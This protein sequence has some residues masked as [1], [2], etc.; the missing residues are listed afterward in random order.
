MIQSIVFGILLLVFGMASNP[1][2]AIAQDTSSNQKPANRSGNRLVHLDEPWEVFHPDHTF[3]R[4]T[5]PQWIGEEGIEL[6]LALGIDDMRDIPTYEAYLRPIL[7]Q[8]KVWEGRA[9]VSIMANRI[10]PEDPHLQEWLNEGVSIE[11]HTADHPCP[12][13]DKG[14]FSLAKSTYDR[15]VDSLFLIPNHEP[16]AFRTPC[17]DGI[18]SHSPRLVAEILLGTTPE[19]RFLKMSSSVGL[20]FTAADPDASPDLVL[21]PGGA[22]RFLRYRRPGYIGYIENYPFP[23]LV[24]NR[25]WE[26][27]FNMPD[28]YEGSALSGNNSPQTLHDM[29]LAIDWIAKKQ[30]VWMLCFHP[31]QWIDNTNVIEILRHA[32][33]THAGKVRTLNLRD[34][35]ERLEKNLLL[36]QPL[37]RADGSDNGVR[38]VDLSN[39]GTMDV[40]IGNPD[41]QVTR[42]W[43]PDN[44][45]WTDHDFPVALVD[46]QGRPTGARF[47]LIHADGRPSLFHSNEKSRGAWQLTA[48]GWVR[49]DLL[50]QGLELDGQ[51]VLGAVN[52]VDAGLRFR[53]LDGDG[54]TECI[55]ARPGVQAVFQWNP[56]ANEWARLELELPEGLSLV[57]VD[58]QDNGV[59]FVDING[60]GREDLI[61][62]NPQEYGLWFYV[63]KPF[64]GFTR[65]F[66]REIIRQSRGT[67]PEIPM[68]V[69]GGE[70]SNNGAWFKFDH[71]WVQNEETAH[72]ANHVDRLTFAELAN[73]LQPPPSDPEVS[74]VQMRTAGDYVIELVAH[75]LQITDPVYFDWDADGSLWVVEMRDYPLGSKGGGRIR[76]LQDFD[77]DGF[78]ETAVTFIEDLR[79]PSG[80]YPWRDGLLISAAPNLLYA[81]DTTGDGKADSVEVLF[82]GFGEGNQQH[83]F[84]GFELGLDNWIHG[85]NGD[86]GGR[87][88]SVRTGQT[89]DISGRDFKFR[90][91]TG[92]LIPTSGQTQYTRR[93]DDWGNWFGGANNSLG[94]H[95]KFP[96]EAL[97]RNPR[98]AVRSARQ[99]YAQY[100][101]ANAVHPIARPQQ[102]FNDVGTAGHVTSANS[103]SPYRDDLFEDDFATS[104]FISEPTYNLVRREVLR[105][106]G[107]SF[108]SERSSNEG[109]EEFLASQ[110]P[111]FRPTLVRT[112]PDAALYVADMYRWV[113]EH[114]EWI[115]AD[116][117]ARMDVRAGEDRGRLYRIRPKDRALRPVHRLD[118]AQPAGWVDALRHPNGWVR[119]TAHRLFL[120]N[121]PSGMVA[122]LTGLVRNEPSPKTRLQA[123]CILDGLSG[124][125]PELLVDALEDPEPMIR[126]HAV[127]IAEPWLKQASTENPLDPA[128]ARLLL[129]RVTDPN[130]RVRF[131]LALSLGEWND[132]IAGNALAQLLL[133]E[134]T[135][136]DMRIAVLSSAVPHASEMLTAIIHSNSES[137]HT[138]A[139][140]EHLLD[141]VLRDGPS[142]DLN[143][144]LS[145]LAQADDATGNAG[146]KLHA[147]VTLLEAA[148]RL[149]AQAVNLENIDGAH[150]LKLARQIVIDRTALMTDRLAAIR[151][152]TH[153]PASSTDVAPIL[154]SLLHVSTSV[155]IQLEIIQRLGRWSDISIATGLLDRWAEVGPQIRSA[156]SATVLKEETWTAA[157]LQRVQSREITVT[158]INASARQALLNHKSEGVRTQAIDLFQPVTTERDEV[159]QDYLKKMRGVTGQ[160]ERG[161]EIFST[162]CGYCHQA[163]N[164]GHGAGPN[165]AMVHD[166]S[167]ES[168][169]EAV[170][171][172]NRA[173]ED[174]YRSYRAETRDGDVYSG[175]ILSESGNSITLLGLSGDTV[176]LLRENLAALTSSAAS[177]MP[178]GFEAFLSPQAMADLLTFIRASATPAKRFAGNRP[179]LVLPDKS[180]TIRL[181][182]ARAEIYG[183]TL[184]YENTY[185][186]LGF[187]SSTEDRASWT[188][189]VEES[190]AWDICLD[191][192]CPDANAGNPFLLIIG[193]V[194]VEGVIEGT[195]TWDDYRQTPIGQIQL[196]PG[197]HRVTLRAV[198]LQGPL[199][200]IREIKLTPTGH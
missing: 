12:I 191:W 124:V 60:D 174:K 89:W 164:V 184:V 46:A 197:R 84:N 186:N 7:E 55:V 199:A 147:M 48:S 79:F 182:A 162:H 127:R 13:L 119:D 140:V 102:R 156:I 51:P 2:G 74:L 116:S 65:G 15:C 4:L 149:G 23:Y 66:S 86:S 87:I 150:H 158:D 93:R 97:K 35:H 17:M 53:D 5:T 78:Y 169:L 132:P 137:P 183:P 36:G 190:G 21:A 157:L 188:F 33:S 185:G 105:P 180:H 30:G 110:D 54:F 62:S 135:Q 6:V 163:G 92:E 192:A 130:P 148:E 16:V 134:M 95:Y 59:R 82:T 76:R 189:D 179:A 40:V 20:A 126:T 139:V 83:R 166:H 43:N 106:H 96:D 3:P 145:A 47:A 19:K 67:L 103:F 72:L 171:D 100:P 115:P 109:S 34:I 70:F 155:E 101:D 181:T 194:Q 98:L 114:P 198:T 10:D 63:Q 61:V 64:L 88:R 41:R 73:G 161:Q 68:I 152:L 187:W 90:P 91:D 138:G 200:D 9:P 160:P 99:L 49:D 117:L 153:E 27:P 32:Y 81:K 31:Y 144:I 170:L 24:G 58:G 146:W 37:R 28:D 112:G 178:E 57:T 172:P 136:E 42:L 107:V 176:T 45:T 195:G 26:I 159:V 193:D 123:L 121:Q 133:A 165:L 39:N 129:D 22:E 56:D 8:L 25:L 111:W 154:L 125:N 94:W 104:I 85:A 143:P 18:N 128:L 75:E 14:D 168:M 151:L 71:M 175:I 1:L 196:Q 167:L 122:A 177:L 173:V 69:R 80:L 108:L 11:A 29:T 118:K 113:I 77:G 142:P 141:L 44:Q 52:G 50:W 120:E 38:L 131:Q